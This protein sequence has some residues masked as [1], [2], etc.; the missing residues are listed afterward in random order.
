ML[1]ILNRYA[2][3]LASVPILV[4]LRE[5][6]CLDRLA[7]T[8]AAFSAEELARE[9]SANR[10][11]LD[12]AIR[13]MVCLEWLHP[14][15]DGRYEATPELRSA[16]ALPARIME[17]YRFPFDQY[18]RGDGGESSL[19]PWL[20]QSE[21]HW[22][23]EHPFLPDYLDGL[24]VLPLL[25]ALRTQERL[26]ID[27]ETL[28]LDVDPAVRSQ[29]ERLFIAKRWAARSGDALQVNRAGRF[30]I[31]RVFITAT[32]ASYMPMFRRADELLFGDAARVFERDAQGHETH[33]DRTVNVIGSGFQ[34]EKFFSALADL[35]I[36]CF[37]GE[38]YESQPKYIVDMGCGDGTLLLRLYEAVRDRTRRGTVLDVHPVIP[39]A[40][41]F[42]EKALV[43]ASRTLAS[44][45][46]IAVRGDIGDPAALV[47]TLQ[48][49]GVEDLHRVLHVRSFLDHDRPFKQPSDRKAAE[50]RPPTGSNVG[51]DSTG[52]LIPSGD[53]VQSTVEHL[54]RW[55]QITNEHGLVVL[56]VHCLPPEVTAR[57]RDESEN[58][59][60]DVYHALSHQFLHDAQTFLSC[61]A[62]AGLFWRE[63]GGAGFPKHLPYTR[64]T[65][66][67]FERRPYLVRRGLP[68]DRAALAQLEEVWPQR[69]SRDAAVDGQFLLEIEG[70]VAASIHCEE[71][72]GTVRL[73]SA[74]LRIG[75]PASHLR[76]LLQFVEQYWALSDAGPVGGIEEC[77]LELAATDAE[78]PVARAVARSVQARVAAY[79]FAVDDD[80]RTAERELGTFSFRWLMAKLQQLGVMRDA[81]EAY[82]L[83]ELVRRLGVVPKYHRYFDALVRRLQ[84]EGLVTVRGSRIETT[85]LVR[86]YAL[87]SVDRQLAEFRE[88]FQQRFPAQ[89][90][91]LNLTVRCLARFDE[92]VTGRIDIT[93][94]VFQDANMDAFTEIFRGG[95]VSDY[96]NRIVADAVHDTVVRLRT[97]VPKVQILEIGAGTGATTA[98]IVE[99]LE[100]LAGSVELCFSD[101]SQSF[102]RNAR[103]RF[104]GSPVPI[105]YRLL[106]IEED[107]SRQG[108]GAHRFDVVVAANVLHDTRDVD[109]SLKQVRRLLKPGGLLILDEY[110]SF[111]DCLFFSGALLHGYWLF[112]DPEKRLRDTCL[113][114]VPQWIGAL[115]RTG[116]AVAGAHVLPTQSLDA[117][118]SQ[119]VMLCEALERDEVEELPSQRPQSELVALVEQQAL[120]VLGEQRASA[121]SAKRPVMDMG[122][123]SLELV[124]LKSLIERHVGVRLAP[125]FLFEHETAEK[126]AAALS[127]IAPAR[128]VERPTPKASAAE[129]LMPEAS[130]AD[131]GSPQPAVVADPQVAAPAR[132]DGDAI[133]IVGM[134]CR[135]PGGA[136]SPEAFWELLDNGRHGIVPMPEG[137]WRWPAF[138]D[139]SGT[140]AGIDRGGFLERI[141]EFDAPFFRTSPKE[142][143]LMDPQQ[144]LLL[145]LSW[146]AIED[147]GH[148]PSELSGRQIGVFAGVCHYDYREVLVHTAEPVDAYVG[149]GSAPSLLANR[150]SYFYDFK[151]PSLTVDT[152]CSS[153][154]FALHHA[155]TAIRR[156]DCEQA[157][158]G[159]ANLMC[160][161]TNTI[162]YYRAGMLS[163]AGVCRTFDHRADGYVRGEGAAMLLL[164]PLAAALADGDSI[165]GLVTGT[166]VNHGGQAASLTAPKPEAQATVIEAAWRAADVAL[167]SV[168]YIEA[169]GTGTP[170]GDPIE[171]GGLI[172]AFERLAR[173]RGEAWPSQRRWSLGSVK[174]NI[175]HLEGAAGLAGVIKI[176]LSIRHQ[177][178]PASLHLDRL[179]PQIDLTGSPF[180]VVGR[181][182]PWLA[183]RDAAGRELPRCAGVSSFGFGGSNAHAV[184][185]EYPHKGNRTVAEDGPYLVPLSARDDER[186]LEQATR[187][188][189]LL[190]EGDRPS[191][192]ALADVAYT[193]QVGREPMDERV[194]F[195]VHGR[196]ELVAALRAYVEGTRTSS[197]C[198]RG[199][200]DVRRDR[201]G[202][203]HARTREAEACVAKGDLAKLAT[204]WVEGVE[205][206]WAR[207]STA[208]GAR[209]VHVPT[210]PFAREHYW[211]ETAAVTRAAALAAPGIVH[212]LLHANSSTLDEQSYRATFSGDEFFLSDH[213]VRVDGRTEHRVLPG[214]AYLEM[215]RAAVEAATPG[216]TASTLLELRSAVWVQPIV[217]NGTT[218][219]SVALAPSDEGP[220]GFEIRTGD[221]GQ[222]I[223]HCQGQAVVS[224]RPAA[225]TLDLETIARRMGQGR[226]EPA[227]V[228]SACTRQGLVHGP[229]F[230]GVTGIDRGSDE[231]LARLRLPQTVEDGLEEYVLHPS[232]MDGAMQA[233]VVLLDGETGSGRP[234]MPFVLESLRVASPCSREMLAWVRYTPG[235][236]AG[237]KA[238]RLDIDLC[239]TRGNVCVE[240]RGLTLRSSGNQVRPAAE[241]AA[242][243]VLA[244]PAWRTAPI[245]PAAAD[246]AEHRV[247]L[248]DFPQIHIEA[249]RASIGQS[250]VLSLQSEPGTTIAQRYG[251][252]ALACFEQIRGILKGSTRGR[253]LLQIAI[254]DREEGALLAGL[255]G[256]LKTAALENPRFTGQIILVHP[257][258]AAEDLGR[259]LRDEKAQHPDPL[260]RYGDD[261]TRQVVR[262]QEIAADGQT[263]PVALR[264]DGVYLIT[265]GRGGLGVLF[266]KEILERTRGAKVVLAGRSA[267][268]G[269]VLVDGLAG[270]AAGRVSYRRADVGDPAQA[271][272]LIESI[273]KEHGRL[274]GIVH[275]AGVLADS[276]L[277]EKDSARFGEV[278][279]PKV[280]GTYNLDQA[281][282]DVQLDFFVLLSSVVGVVGNVGQADYAAA[283][284]FMDHFAAYRNRQVA[285][286]K[287]HGRTRSIGWPL[288]AEGGMQIHPAF[289]EGL[290]KAIGMQPMQTAAGMQ[291][292]HRCLASPHDQIVV[293]AGDP[294]RI[295]RAF[296]AE[297]VPPS[298]PEERPAP[299]AVDEPVLVEKTERYLR[300]QLSGVLQLPSHKIDLQ[301]ALSEYGI[302]SI[303]AMQSI[304]KLEETFGTLPKTLF[305]EHQTVR[306]LAAYFVAQHSQQLKAMFTSPSGETASEAVP[307]R[308]AK[309]PP[310]RRRFS[311]ARDAA[312]AW[313]AQREAVAIVGLS[314]RY[315]EA[316]DVDAYWN[317]LREGKD[318]IVPVPAERWDWQAYYDAGRSK[319]GHHYSKWG[320]F[321]SGVDEFDPLFFNISPR[322]A[323]YIDPQERLFLQ[324]AWKAV[325]DAGYTRARL[326]QASSERGL[327]GEVGVY[328][329]VMWS[330]YQLFGADADI[331][332]RVA[333]FAGNVASIANRVSFALDLH[334]PSMTLDTMCSSSLS[335]IHYAC[336][337]LRL[338]RTSMAIAGGVNVT[339]HPNKYLILS[340]GQFISSDGH[341]QS[342]GVGG[343]GY[344]PGEG[345]GAV[346]LKRLSDAERDGD[347]IYGVIRG[348]A[349]NH[350]GR[351]NGYT[352][353]NPKAQASVIARALAESQTD[354]RHISYVEAHGTGTALGDPIE[355]AALAR[356]FGEH[357]GDKAF[358]L[359]GSAKSN[360]GH[361]ESAAGIAGLTKVLLQMQHRQIVPSLH[362]AQLNPHIDFPE[363]PFVVNQSLRPW[364]APL[365][366]GRE[367]PRIAGLS[368]FGAGGSNAHM[369]IEEY[370][371]PAQEPATTGDAIVP[372]S[373]RTPEQLD[374]KARDLLA[375]LTAR[376]G[377]LDLRSLA[378]TL[379]AGREA[380]EERLCFAVSSVEQLV[381]KLQA[382]VA[383][384]EDIEDAYRGAVKRNKET[385]S[386]FSADD[387]Q[388]AI[389][390][391]IANGQ[392]AKLA[393]LWAR[394]IE[395][396]WTRLY[397]G[398]RPRLISLP[399]YPFAR[400]RYWI[401]VTA[402]RRSTAAVLHP[403]L[404]S[405]TSDLREQRYDSTFTGRESFLADHQVMGRKVLPG[406]AYLEMVRAAVEHAAPR[407]GATA[408]ELRD[409]VWVQPVVVD[410]ETRVSIAL[411]EREDAI[412]FEVYSDQDVVHCQGRAAIV[413][414][415]VPARL[416]LARLA[417]Q[418]TEGRLDRAGVYDACARM[419]IAY[420][421][422]FRAI[423]AVHRG[424]RQVL[425]HLRLPEGVEKSDA[426][427][428]HPNLLDGALQ[429]CVGLFGD[430]PE[431]RLP[432]ALKSLRILSPTVAEM[433]A[434]VRFAHDSALEVEIDLCDV[435]GNVCVELRGLSL[436]AFGSIG[437]STLL[438]VPAWQASEV[439]RGGGIE[440]TG[441][442]VLSL[443]MEPHE[444]VE[445]QYGRHAL[446]LLEQVQAILRSKPEGR[447]L[448]QV[449]V[450]DELLA[451]LSGLLK[452]AALENP[453]FAGQL[454]VVPG[455]V[456][457]EELGRR[458]EEEKT[459]GLEALVRFENGV[460]QVLRWQEV[461]AEEAKPPVA[462]KDGGVY[463]ITG[464]R[465]ALGTL[466]AQE[467]LAQTADARVILTGRGKADAV[468]S[469]RRISYRQVDLGRL[470]DVQR[471]IA[472]VEADYGRLDGILHSAG[473]LSDQFLLKKTGAALSDVLEPKVAGTVHLDEATRDIALDFFVLFSSFAGAMGNVG[474]ADYAAA[475]GFMDRFAAHRNRQVAAGQRRGRTLS[476]NWPLWQ[477]GGMGIDEA[478]LAALRQR[479]GMQ[480]MQTA[481]GL[482]AFH[483]SLA[484][485]CD[486]ALVA[487]GDKAQLRR[488]LAAE[489][490]AVPER[491]PLPRAATAAETSSADLLEKTQQYFRRQFSELLKVAAPK[492]DP[493][494]PLEQYGI[495]SVLALQLINKLEQTFGALAKTLLFEYQT[496]RDL[497]R[498]FIRQHAAQLQ[499]LF[500]PAAAPSMPSAP[501]AV[502]AKPVASRR[503]G[504]LAAAPRTA[505]AESDAIAIIGLSGRYP[506]AI[507]VAAYWENLRDGK[508]CIV[509]VPK[510]RWDWR[511]YFSEDRTQSGHHYSKWGGFVSGVD[512]FDPLFFNISPKEAKYIDPQERLFLQHAWMAIEDAGYT[513]ASLQASH[514]GGTAGRAGVYAGVMWGEYQL[515]GVE[516]S[517]RG[518]RLGIAGSTASVANRVSYALN[519]HGPS[520]TVDTM[521]SSSLTAIHLA[522]QDLKQGRCSLAIAGGVNVSIHPNKYLALSAGQFIS[523]DGHCQSFGE[524][525]DG[526]IPGE[527]VGVV[528]L[529][530][531]S[532]ARRDGDHIYG[533]IRGSALNHGGK[534]N[535]YTVPNPQAQ[536]GAVSQALEESGTDARHVSY[537][538]AHGTGTK[539]GDPIE[540][541]ALSKAFGQYTQDTGFCLIGSAKSNIGHCESAAGIAGL[542]K[543]LLQ[544]QHRQI[545]PSLHSARLNPYI[546]FDS[547]PFVVNQ[548]LRPWDAP[549]VDGRTLPRIAGISSFGA[550]GS[551]AHLI[552]EE[553]QAPPEQP[554]A[555]GNVA[556]VLSARTAAQLQQKVR[557]LL[558]FI[559]A[560][561]AAI[562]LAAVAYTLQVGREP[563]EERLGFVAGSIEQLVAKLEAHGAGDQ[564]IEDLYQGQVKR[565]KEA[566]SVFSA[567]PDL[568]QTVEKWIANRNLSRLLDL[569][570]KGLEVDWAGLYGE[571]KPR[572][573]ALPVYPFARERHWVDP[574]PAR[575]T[576]TLAASVLH[577]LLHGN[578]SN[579]TA[580]SYRSTFTGEELFVAE[581]NGQKVLPA[582]ACL[583]MARAAIGHAMPVP[584]ES[585]V[586]ELHD[587]TWAQPI[588][589]GGLR[590]VD[591]GLFV[592][593]NGR[594]AYEIYSQDGEREIVHFQGH[595]AW[596]WEAAPATVD[597]AQLKGQ[598]QR[599][600]PLHVPLVS[601]E[602]VLHPTLLDAALHAVQDSQEF[603]GPVSLQRLRIV[604]SCASGMFAW[605]RPA[606]GGG[607]DIDLCDGRGKVAVQMRGLTLLSRRI[608][609]VETV[610]AEAVSVETVIEQAP[611]PVAPALAVYREI[612]FLSA[613]PVEGRKPAA[614]TLAAPAATASPASSAGR[615][616]IA[617]SNA[618]VAA[619]SA[620]ATS[621]VRLYESNG[622]IFSIE[623]AASRAQNTI[624]HLLQALERVQQEP[625]LKVLMLSGIEH[626][627]LTGDREEYN[628][629]VDQKLFQRLAE[630]PYPVIAALQGDV[631]GAGFLAAALCDFVVC[632]EDARYGFTEAERRFHPTAAEAVLL[633]ERFGKA[634]VERFLFGSAD[635]SGRELRSDG[636][637]CPIVS[638]FEVEARAGQL[639]SALAS[640]SQE[641]LRLLKEH[642]SR[643]IAELARALTRVEVTEAA[644]SEARPEEIAIVRYGRTGLKD[645]LPD[646]SAYRAVVLVAEDPDVPDDAAVD[647]QRL[648][649]GAEIPIIAA[650]PGDAR[651]N[652]WLVGL[653]CDARVYAGSGVYSSAH[654]GPALEQAAAA[655]FAHRFGHEAASEILLTGADYSGAELRQRGGAAFVEESDRVLPAAMHLAAVWS[656]LPRATLAGQ[657]KQT[658]AAL[659]ERSLSSATAS[660][661]TEEALAAPGSIPLQSRVVTATVHPDGI[662]AVRM[663]DRE[664]KNM[665]SEALAEGIREV[666]AHIARTPSYKV[667]VLTGYDTYFASGGTKESLVSI[668]EGK[669]RFTDSGVFHVALECPLPVIA[670][671]QGHGIGAGWSMGMFADLVLLSEESRYVSPYMSY[672]FT[673]GAGATYSLPQKLG[674]DLAHESLLTAQQ[675]AGR[676]LKDRGL[677]LR[678]LPRTE[679]TA[680]AMAL[681]K[682]IAR[683]SRSRLIE[684]KRQ[685]TAHVHQRLEETYQRELEMHEKT[686]VGR[687]DTLAQIHSHF[688]HD[689]QTPA[690]VPPSRPEPQPQSNPQPASLAGESS[691]SVMAT[692]RR[693]LAN[694]LLLQESD[695]DD[696]AQFVDLGLDSITGVTWVRKINE[697]YGT[698]IEATKV[699]S[700]PTLA[701]LSRYVEEEAR[702]AG[703]LAVPAAPAEAPPAPR[704]E[705]PV[706]RA[707]VAAPVLSRR[708]RSASR[709]VT[710]PPASRGPEPIAVIGMAGQFPQAKNLEE[711]WR[712]IAEGKNCVTQVQ[713]WDVDTYYQPGEPVPG[714]TYS[715][716]MGAL[717]DYALF[718][719]LFFNISPTEAECMDPQQRLFLQACWHSIENAGYDPRSLSGSRCGVFV[720]CGTSDYQQLSREHSWSAQGFTGRAMSILAARIS[721][722]LNLRGASM[723]IDTACSSSLVAL[724]NACDSLSSGGSDMALAGGVYVMAGP[725]MHIMTAQ[726][727]MLSP[728]G[729]CYTFDDR[730]DGFVPG[731]GVGV[732][733][734]KRLSD[735]ERDGDIIQA[736]IRGWGVN[737]DGKTNGI[738]APNPESQTRLEQDVYDRYGIDP[739]AIQLVEAHGTGTKL[740]DPIEVEGLKNA[741]RKYTQKKDYC[742]IGSVKSNIGHTLAAA[743]IAGALKLVLALQ[744]KVL[745]P[746][747]NF[748]RLNEHIDLR[749]SPF[750]VNTQSREWKV[751]GPAQRQAAISSFG[752]SGTN[753]HVVLAEYPAPPETERAVP[754][755]CLVPISARTAD[756]L[757]QKVRDLLAHVRGTGRSLQLAD[758]AYTLQVGRAAM[759]ERLGFV[760]STVDELAENLQAWLDG[761]PNVENVHRGQVKRDQEGISVISQ[762]DEVKDAVVEKLMARQKLSKLLRLWVQGLDLDWTRL[763]GEG[764]PRRVSL[765]VYPFARERY[766]IEP[767]VDA[768]VAAAGMHPLLH[769]NDSALREQ[770]YSATFTGE[771]PFLKDHRVRTGGRDVHKVLPAVAY[772]EMVRAAIQQTWPGQLESA[773]LELHDTIWLKPIVVERPEEVS[774][775]LFPA[776]GD[777]VDYE[778]STVSDGQSTVHC[779]GQASFLRGSAPARIDLARLRGRMGAESLEASGVYARFAA[780]GLHYGPAHQGIT[781]IRRG[782]R[783]LL[784]ELAL[785]AVVEAGRHPYVLHP[786]LLDS[787]LQASIG[788]TAEASSVPDKPAV[789]FALESLLVLSPC[790]KAM[791]AWVRISGGSSPGDLEVDIDLCD[792]EGSVCV[793]MRGFALRL[794]GGEVMPVLSG[795]KL[796]IKNDVSFD[797]HLYAT[798]IDDV[799]AGR[800][801]IDEAAELG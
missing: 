165:Y 577:P 313:P 381:E 350:G 732:V 681:A 617:L 29:I 562:D 84:D 159:A 670:A 222:E 133:A 594:I 4:A 109:L 482:R 386:L 141:D 65:L 135:F 437:T 469:N 382:Y 343:D 57:Y 408:L 799:A 397:P 537:I 37:E 249:L 547:T 788:L 256:L 660:D 104:A 8:G 148:R 523:S 672:G 603:R 1:E 726:S 485:S 679:V 66:N 70:V 530:R 283:N 385:L 605:V 781:A 169:H 231:L 92:I 258:T 768:Q 367:G 529:K 486:Q 391:W 431:P 633:E 336:Q 369:I 728:E 12:V 167:D 717:D 261:G 501:A 232:L 50:Q 147:A 730:A 162:A 791:I 233:A 795:P 680:A 72:N 772:L 619:S 307:P 351:T 541:T 754:G 244:V 645:A 277:L 517:A 751:E 495:D 513:R 528:V 188:L 130:V 255:S 241:A 41:D 692:L 91:L 627:F 97:G 116:F 263:P 376:T 756:Q 542:T 245:G 45:G 215:V 703:T 654:A 749:E 176:L 275:G 171:I 318:C 612:P 752:F 489:R 422:A 571:D 420:G 661:R 218:Q 737:Q 573:I 636:W 294:A 240:M 238:P 440:L 419:G 449:V 708:R 28:R 179:N 88:R 108:F 770:R 193:L 465:G 763:Y 157:L 153:S 656:K 534:T 711:F 511:E 144:R 368:S 683:A 657:K 682:Q 722:F 566:L 491:A 48:T 723:A 521:C 390:R 691:S 402:N 107:L 110:T 83:E 531:L 136:E 546:D 301:V 309:T 280:T 498:Y 729:N 634:R 31:D 760:V 217:V 744:R 637:T 774:I 67:H 297:P 484:L 35:V 734:L 533:V 100:P 360:I 300:K 383:G 200:V 789:P 120:L 396:D 639:A 152:A 378:W 539:L 319:D 334:G 111:K 706:V 16:S 581:E 242:A 438:A 324:H 349:L 36:R 196:E 493:E 413:P 674:R 427:V 355:I 119:S 322:E 794:T 622:G 404:H 478:S 604:S 370:V 375:F 56:E 678:I 265:G 101:I 203:A 410:G 629:A 567:D 583:E 22:N 225:G 357:T 716:W 479:V 13:M 490:P 606:E 696:D 239:D 626:C 473:M 219:V 499:A 204:L 272:E 689:V 742:A 757:T 21:R 494:A 99:R 664:A 298:A 346:V 595:A 701:Q 254:A 460:R 271:R 709:F 618:G 143:N 284:G 642:L 690:A 405:N 515:F 266:A 750:Y 445:R 317:N 314:G 341:C 545:A 331:P 339:V 740:G 638:W 510:E 600:V 34:H 59:H 134:A 311:P 259:Y 278:L 164:K 720:G 718:D 250:E 585:P 398:A 287:R 532:E 412:D 23:S 146:R 269:E 758:I 538:E 433:V 46:H 406:V 185:E 425:A 5:R 229:S 614:I 719:P 415:T 766:W 221:A 503:T 257:D 565:N 166:A 394:G 467:I 325:E 352:V 544:M 310:A 650:L 686:F 137:R 63:G 548:T 589:V 443:R 561:Q 724:A 42:N 207:L 178:I 446:A 759:E 155:V 700:H 597:L 281:S 748:E 481:A 268:S 684:L 558:E 177:S 96:F 725:E 150:L 74:C 439:V 315:P 518:N 535:G 303:L 771:E 507:D 337:D 688:D 733:L 488:T 25:L 90:G 543:V 274:D 454:I 264:D 502:P 457:A 236:G 3:G 189:E 613:A 302:D 359:I 156:G 651:G 434:W 289:R 694:E 570:V 607:V 20:E 129:E 731:E 79:P 741:F 172:Q 52:R 198:H 223:V 384:D 552:V 685:L 85:P 312:A 747:I 665:F 212:P 399:T 151:G 430:S 721:Y 652:A 27:G 19:E 444:P 574:L 590:P 568:Q 699:Y 658:E 417:E 9:F 796:P 64:V 328:V 738:T 282:S 663:E 549:V 745:P 697:T 677:A 123:D 330:E 227:A 435:D 514:G 464:G 630:F 15:A 599:V 160:S 191:A 470:E 407:E 304:N 47:E 765:P 786:S 295:R 190:T 138:V 288:W 550:G 736:V 468:E 591:I 784:A 89:A 213:R 451:G 576:A 121:Y 705:E 181:N 643:R 98:A 363:T 122:L 335:A 403:L 421:P 38:D 393:E 621:P 253:V 625:A 139:V 356:A 115:E 461:A 183:P 374:E 801:S 373:A 459:G 628:R 124:E 579:L 192:P 80:P 247:I 416:D 323:Q 211:I 60:F 290:E 423:T 704:A 727:G 209:R 560:R 26:R 743:G 251:D 296:L 783:E 103:R 286:G 424:N 662:V 648:I 602:Y 456:S 616:R 358:C 184:I 299:A 267:W 792:A 43:E 306:A 610:S 519:L 463:L 293:V 347:H 338:G 372:L 557:D 361:C 125:T 450:T 316:A 377:P 174:T 49:N 77:R 273:R 30:V 687:A 797:G 94:V 186:L 592:E 366:D 447:V 86:E 525:G 655:L 11:Y 237:D 428:L 778:I 400:E 75:A 762:D 707:A 332:D 388:Q 611:V 320:G 51:I 389:D 787:A 126:M 631:I 584:P 669:T 500:A 348:S 609:S 182:E 220:I 572:R 82:E 308:A 641:A 608:E 775:A 526:Y 270:P 365:I 512:E 214:V 202:A 62:E 195:V 291:A 785:P 252:H 163:H 18:V 58:F 142:A 578:T 780:M 342:F 505:A 105:D 87:T 586:L 432:F 714:K 117:T 480:P 492:I 644:A 777:C 224:P 426:Y 551:N 746:T 199:R 248:C 208:R 436:R 582:M 260:V 713:R 671:M 442:H 702:Q 798:L 472:E 563:M 504:R 471:L 755:K 78:V 509:E 575:P 553:Y 623:I 114:G 40:V 371:A 646:L 14:V 767:V 73:T 596:S 647:L 411:S 276:F 635:S 580:Q 32:V 353:P 536:S 587:I 466:F 615:A 569:W 118:C 55:S 516:A 230:Q 782:D 234:R 462:F 401:D 112:E 527:G 676:E 601:N 235:S 556:I 128:Q 329:G 735:A 327:S 154:L 71:Q 693:L 305:F 161:P 216:R 392:F 132:N 753:A 6:G 345:V 33:V 715:Q 487:E 106:N 326:Q 228:Y 10:G 145:E 779:H 497:S 158:V 588:V 7:G 632:S 95:R 559:R 333:G 554:V 205:P 508:D 44:I 170:L 354:A 522:C 175:G 2:H 187:L 194:A 790:T 140:H 800:L 476:I 262:W 61:A 769:R 453:S 68:E 279:A 793:Q 764:K 773:V 54:K 131:G 418:L 474:Q 226:L 695:V 540:I 666:F 598:G 17:L 102:L 483:R 429:A 739:A 364:E 180:H 649:V 395:P 659:Q 206:D 380:M 93:H 292:F 452:T 387:L 39:V 76:D 496:I 653:A 458:L 409:T 340:V 210:Y 675:V 69:R 113:L 620:S 475:N 673:P 524:G 640:R 593:D 564:A 344:I 776:D 127:A 506:E 149:T 362:S 448:L 667:V 761:R 414:R 698:S 668:Q 379:Q 710:N 197:N 712:N 455:D 201:G 173:A 53:M 168:G 555:A 624:G 285:A 81:G 441:H 246:D 477:A 24:L 520:M 321:I 243:C